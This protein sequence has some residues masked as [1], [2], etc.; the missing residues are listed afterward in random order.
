MYVP[1][2]MYVLGPSVY[3]A[4]QTDS[5]ING[6][7]EMHRTPPALVAAFLRH[8][9]EAHP[10]LTCPTR[11]SKSQ[12]SSVRLS[13]RLDKQRWLRPVRRLRILGICTTILN[14]LTHLITLLL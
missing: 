12:P 14:A 7:F 8:F 11:P 1:G 4:W 10:L 6:V 5:H 13:I 3:I 9:I 2:A